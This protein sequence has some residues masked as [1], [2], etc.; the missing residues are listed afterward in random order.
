MRSLFLALGF[1]TCLS[2][3]AQTP[4]WLELASFP[5]LGR[6]DAIAFEINGRIYCGT[7]NHGGFSQSSRFF[8]FDLN[9]GN[10]EEVASFPGENRQ[11]A[12]AVTY[13]SKAYL[14]GGV[15]PATEAL[16]DVWEYDPQSDSW[17]Q[18]GELPF[19]ARWA[20]AGTNFEN[21]IVLASGRDE[22]EYF[23]DAWH[24]QPVSDS[25]TQI[26]N[27]PT[28]PRF[29]MV[30][31]TLYDDAY[32]GLG[33]DCTNTLSNQFWRYSS[34]L[35]VWEEIAPFPGGG[36]WYA[37]V[38]TLDGKAYTGTGM[39]ESNVFYNDWW[40]YDPLAKNWS[41]TTN[42]PC[43]LRG[44]SAC[45]VAGTGIVLLT[46]LDKD[47]NR[48]SKVRQF[49][50]PSNQPVPSSFLYSVSESSLRV[51]NSAPNQYFRIFDLHGKMVYEL[52]SSEDHFEVDLSSLASGMY[53]A[54][55]MES[56]GLSWSHKF[57]KI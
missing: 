11:Y 21:G 44:A 13:E 20:S 28:L 6:D 17:T 31:F 22:D 2:S 16:N 19:P 41:P 15:N 24:Y 14:F 46:G 55:Q 48:L 42:F 18:M 34:D 45:S 49:H 57:V 50:K 27:L 38:G 8:A 26:T 52:I 40:E 35:S 53:V 33:K 3:Y 47:Y 7:G 37:S 51:I 32:F 43:E 1:L 10:W 30:S 5:S 29:E 9:S 54:I 23:N 56:E 25:W 12:T 4:S 36:R 39:D